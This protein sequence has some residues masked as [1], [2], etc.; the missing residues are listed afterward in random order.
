MTYHAPAY[1]DGYLKAS[2]AIRPPRPTVGP[3][4]EMWLGMVTGVMLNNEIDVCGDAKETC[5]TLTIQMLWDTHSKVYRSPIFTLIGSM[6]L[7]MRRTVMCWFQGIRR[8]L[9][10]AAKRVT[11]KCDLVQFTQATGLFP[12]SF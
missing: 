2:I 3:T 9:C 5:S 4:L 10:T 12:L 7:L 8:S 1:V 11:I 6:S